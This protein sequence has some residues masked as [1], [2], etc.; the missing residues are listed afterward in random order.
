MEYIIIQKSNEVV[1]VI[2]KVKS[3]LKEILDGE[4]DTT[5]ENSEEE[6][7]TETV[8]LEER[9]QKKIDRFKETE[10]LDEQYETNNERK[11]RFISIEEFL[12]RKNTQEFEREIHSLRKIKTEKIDKSNENSD[13]D[14]L[15]QDF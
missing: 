8:D 6:N 1:K 12:D 5:K 14:D 2:Q 10:E 13:S 15:F 11:S 3:D 4:V 7:E 9:R